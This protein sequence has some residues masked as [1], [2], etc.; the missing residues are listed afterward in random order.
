MADL[1]GGSHPEEDLEVDEDDLMPDLNA[2]EEVAG[3]SGSGDIITSGRVPTQPKDDDFVARE[4][5]G[6]R[7]TSPYMTKYERA[8]IIGTRALQISMNA[9]V[10]V[11]TEGETDPMAIAEKEL[12]AK[13][14]PFI[15]RRF[16]PDGTYEDWKVEELMQDP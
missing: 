5:E 7:R 6:P 11:D 14:I 16:L 10:M 3:G 12:V 1:G 15:V 2:D 8:R 13:V 4:A 9:P